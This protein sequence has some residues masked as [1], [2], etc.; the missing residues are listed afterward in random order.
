MELSAL[1]HVSGIESTTICLTMNS[2]PSWPGDALEK[3]AAEL[4][5]IVEVG[6]KLNEYHSIRKQQLINGCSAGV[7]PQSGSRV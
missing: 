2:T 5:T 7:D 3:V 4:S 6:V 1:W